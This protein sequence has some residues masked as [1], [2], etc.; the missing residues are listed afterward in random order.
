MKDR[1][2]IYS[3]LQL[4]IFVLSLVTN[5]Y[6]I[7]T[8]SITILMLMVTLDKLGRGIVLRELMAL[9]GCFVCLLMPLL[10]YEIYND[11]NPLAILWVKYMPIG[12]DYYFPYVLPAM[13]GFIFAL[14]YPFRKKASDEGEKLQLTLT[15]ARQTLSQNPYVGVYLLVTGVT[16]F[17]FTAY[18]PGVI[19]FVFLLFFMASFAGFLYVYFTPHIRYKYPILLLF[20][21]FI[22]YNAL[23]SGMFTIVA[24]MG[25]TMFSFF[26]VGKKIPIWRKVSFFLLGAFTLFVIQTVKQKYRMITWKGEFEGNRAVLFTDLIGEQVI[27]NPAAL[28]TTDALF[29]IYYRTN[30]GF[31][32]ALVLR[33]IPRLQPYDNGE[34]L[35]LVFASA[36]VPR[37]FWADKPESGGKFNMKYYS[38]MTIKGYSTNVSPI[39]EAYGS[40]GAVGGIL[41]MIGLGFFIRWSYRK[42]FVIANKV[43]LI[44]FW[45]PVL[46]YQT[47]YS[48]ETD[49]LQIVN[50]LVKGAFF[51]LILYKVLPIVFGIATGRNRKSVLPDYTLEVPRR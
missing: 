13:T 45:I 24:Y 14:C 15:K 35:G 29:P 47:T 43:P 32:I 21:A 10:G 41:Y 40:F 4:V 42:I 18:L 11:R 20:G 46:F 51:M 39:G 27:D 26:F 16:V 6:G 50:S 25:I 36:F 1:D 7:L 49:T 19:Q 44:I 17:T 48:L 28:F 12:I 2:Y 22:L 8:Y 9:H 31:N 33:R 38:G 3:Y 5:W 23:Q 34:H 30:Q 37:L